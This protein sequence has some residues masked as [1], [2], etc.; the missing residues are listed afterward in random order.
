MCW[1][2]FP[3]IIG[4][5]QATET[6]KLLLGT[7]ETLVGRLLLFD[8]LRMRFRELKLRKD[9]NCPICGEHRTIHELIDYNQF[10]GITTEPEE[11]LPSDWEIDPVQ[12]KSMLDQ[13]EPL[14]LLD[15]RSPTNGTSA[16]YLGRI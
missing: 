10:C 16:G 13:G 8:A 11:N 2:S 14:Y 6:V 12:L 15:V 3:G 1:E 9:P 5:I 4:V 7:G